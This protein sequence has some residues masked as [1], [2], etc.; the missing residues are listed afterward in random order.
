MDLKSA[1][2]QKK[3]PQELNDSDYGERKRQIRDKAQEIFLKYGYRKT[4]IEDIGKACGLGKAALYHY[5]KNKEEILAE[6][7]RAEGRKVLDQARAA[8]QAAPDP[9]SKLTAMIKATLMA[10]NE[11]GDGLI[12]TRTRLELAEALPIA[13]QAFQQLQDESTGLLW[14]ILKEGEKEGVFRKISSPSI[15]RLITS[16]LRGVVLHLFELG[17]PQQAEEAI[18]ATMNLFFEG[19]CK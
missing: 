16:G 17:N 8:I 12:G 19:L 13:G 14:N 6:V 5:F 4:T 7:V 3:R 18:E 10:T 11:I 2:L 1:Q 9:K 15:P